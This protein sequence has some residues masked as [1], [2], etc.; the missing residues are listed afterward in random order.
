[1][2]IFIFGGTGDLAQRK[3]LP[4]LA[5]GSRQKRSGRAE[6]TPAVEGCLIRFFNKRG[7]LRERSEPLS[8]SELPAFLLLPVSVSRRQDLRDSYLRSSLLQLTALWV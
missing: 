8:C 1:M 7:L 2:N 4:A 3:L 6:R 5:G